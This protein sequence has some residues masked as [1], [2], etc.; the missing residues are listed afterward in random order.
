M[1]ELSRWLFIA[2]LLIS[3]PVRAVIVMVQDRRRGKVRTW[4]LCWHIVRFYDSGLIDKP[5]LLRQVQRQLEE[6]E[7]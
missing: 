4:K 2:F 6:W 5:D 1:P 3:R 7:G